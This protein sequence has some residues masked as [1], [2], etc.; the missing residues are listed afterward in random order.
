[1]RKSKLHV[2]FGMNDKEIITHIEGNGY[3]LIAAATQ[4]LHAFYATFRKSGDGEMFKE[5]IRG[6]VNAEKSPVWADGD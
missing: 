5:I 4:A 6:I 1:M 3:E 2:E